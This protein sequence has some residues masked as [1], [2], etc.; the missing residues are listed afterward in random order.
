MDAVAIAQYVF[1]K[2][3]DFENQAVDLLA[4]GNIKTIE[5]YR[6]VMG[7]LSM[8]RTLRQ[9]LREALQMQG[10]DFDE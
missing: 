10:D 2:L 7:E 9:D 4:G 1:K 3:N 5:E 6:Y 8:L